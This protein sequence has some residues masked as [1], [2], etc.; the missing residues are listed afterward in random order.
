M[1]CQ[2][3]RAQM[4]TKIHDRPIIDGLNQHASSCDIP[5]QNYQCLNLATLPAM[6]QYDTK[7]ISCCSDYRI[8]R[9]IWGM[10]KNV[11]Q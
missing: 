8:D 5:N 3:V 1:L 9:H 7:F 11:L 4:S 10:G 2:N 6:D